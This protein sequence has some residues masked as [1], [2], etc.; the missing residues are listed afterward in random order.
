MC[1]VFGCIRQPRREQYQHELVLDAIALFVP[2]RDLAFELCFSLF[3]LRLGRYY[4]R[5]HDPKRPSCF[6]S[7][8]CLLALPI[9][10]CAGGY[11]GLHTFQS[12]RF[13][14]K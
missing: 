6:A 4:V 5:T 13:N 14:N 8:V 3:V 10:L 7:L 12:N 11:I 9:A 1:T 2:P